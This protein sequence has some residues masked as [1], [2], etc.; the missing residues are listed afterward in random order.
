MYSPDIEKIC[1]LC[2]NAKAVKGIAEHMAC[3]VHGGYVPCSR[4]AC[5]KF[6]YDIFKKKV[7]RHKSLDNQD[8]DPEMFKL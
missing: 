7:R 3:D 1:A 6:K 5:D 4:E 8:F 2:V